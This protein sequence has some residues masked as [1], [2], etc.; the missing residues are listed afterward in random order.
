MTAADRTEDRGLARVVALTIE[1]VGLQTGELAVGGLMTTMFGQSELDVLDMP[2]QTFT[3]TL[4]NAP[5][6]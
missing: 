6:E 3:V 2:F 4:Y 5:P 1:T